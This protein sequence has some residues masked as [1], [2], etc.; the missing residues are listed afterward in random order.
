[1][2]RIINSFIFSAIHIS[3]IAGIYGLFVSENHNPIITFSLNFL[4]T[5]IYYN[6]SR[7]LQIKEYSKLKE[8]AHLSWISKNLTEL[9]FAIGFSIL[10]ILVLTKFNFFFNYTFGIILALCYILF[11][12]VPLIKNGIIGF[13]WALL[14]YFF[15]TKS[16]HVLDPL[17][18]FN[19]LFFSYLSFWYDLKDINENQIYKLIGKKKYFIILFI[20][21]GILSA[22]FYIVYDAIAAIILFSFLYFSL[23]FV[24]KINRYKVYMI[25]IDSLILLPFLISIVK[26]LKNK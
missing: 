11:R 25:V 15:S 26:N 20:W 23:L 24:E 13:S 17:F 1:M 2:H 21:L 9:I 16:I 19:L 22:S 5:F 3:I 6:F 12:K 7:I 14:P 18:L 4:T 8:S 10:L